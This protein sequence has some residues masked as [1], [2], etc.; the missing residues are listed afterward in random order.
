MPLESLEYRLSSLQFEKI[1]VLGSGNFGTVILYK[2]EGQDPQIKSLCDEFG[3]IAVKLSDPI[4]KKVRVS[5]IHF[6][7]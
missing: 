4:D 7:L 6:L 1:R 3:R 2:Y 5:I